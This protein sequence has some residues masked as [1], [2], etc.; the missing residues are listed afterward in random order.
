LRMW[1]SIKVKV[2]DGCNCCTGRMRS[3]IVM[4]QN[5]NCSQTSTSLWSDCRPKMISQRIGIW[6]TGDG[7]SPRRVMFQDNASFIPKESQHNLSC[8]WLR[9]E[10]LGFWWW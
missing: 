4:L 3:S 2:S 5:D 10:L 7:V 6:R 9:P 1:K 8:R